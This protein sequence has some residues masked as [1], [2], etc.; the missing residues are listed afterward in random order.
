MDTGIHVLDNV[1]TAEQCQ[2][3]T[4]CFERCA[5]STPSRDYNDA[6]IV[7]YNHLR[8]DGLGRPVVQAAAELAASI[9]RK[10]FCVSDELVEAVF[11][12]KI[13]TGQKH[14]LHTDNTKPDGTPNHTP[15]R[16]Y[17]SLFYLN[18]EFGGGELVFPNQDKVVRPRAG[19]FV[20]FPSSP[21]Y[22]HQVLPVLYGNRYSMPVWFTNRLVNKL[23]L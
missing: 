5:P 15:Q 20:A 12:A 18:E 7:H 9:V 1:L 23:V 22:A 8:T 2:L 14:I 4:A 13:W 16:T 6:P 19:M 10:L 17:S 21:P 11:L 3:L